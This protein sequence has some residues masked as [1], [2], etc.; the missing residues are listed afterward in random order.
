MFVI[1]YHGE[2]HCD[3]QAISS[4]GNPGEMPVGGAITISE[5]LINDPTTDNGSEVSTESVCHHD[6]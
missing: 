1:K 6:E 5:V 2:Q 4:E 3:N